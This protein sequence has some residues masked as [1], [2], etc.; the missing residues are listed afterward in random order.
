[1][2]RVKL[3]ILFG[4]NLPLS[5]FYFDDLRELTKREDNL[6]QRNDSQDLLEYDR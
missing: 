2:L 6:S 1:M 3:A 4:S 5:D